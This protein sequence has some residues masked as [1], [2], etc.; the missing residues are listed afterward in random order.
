MLDWKLHF[1][2]M[3]IVWLV[4]VLIVVKLTIQSAEYTYIKHSVTKEDKDKKNN[5]S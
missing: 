2:I 4:N 3:I 1:F 5:I